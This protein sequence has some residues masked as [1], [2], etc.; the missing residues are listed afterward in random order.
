MKISRPDY[1]DKIR[2]KTENRWKQLEGDPELAAPWH[3]LFKQVQSTRHVISELLQ[4][5]DDAGATE[6][7]SRIE[8]KI[9]TFA[10]NGQ[11]F[12]EDD[13]ASLCRFGYSNKRLL[14]TIGFRGIGFKS[15]FSLGDTV[16]LLTPTLTVAFHRKNFTLPV[17]FDREATKDRN[18]Q[19]LVEIAD[20]Q[21]QKD[22]SNNMQVWLNSPFSLL[23]FNHIRR[24]KLGDNDLHWN[25]LGTGP[26]PNSEW[27]ALQGQENPYLVIRSSDEP[28]PDEALK[29]I[30]DE[31]LLDLAENT[32][33]PPC[34][35]EIVLGALGQFFVVLPTEIKTSLPFAVNAP[36]VQE[37][38]RLK[39]KD[40]GISPTNR[41]LLQR[42]GQ[43][44]A[45]AMLYWLERDD[46][47]TS[48]RAKAYDLLPTPS[49]MS[50]SLESAC[51]Q[52][53]VDAFTNAIQGKPYVLTNEGNLV[54]AKQCISVPSALWEI[55]TRDEIIA[56]LDTK[57]LNP[58]LLSNAISQSNQQKL[59]KYRAILTA[60]LDVFLHI[61]TT[62]H[63]PRPKNW[64]A[65]LE[66]WQL[67]T[68]GNYYWK[69]KELNLYPVKGENVLYSAKK[70]TRLGE[71]K[72]L[73]SEK[74]WDFLAMHLLVL[75]SDWLHYLAER[76]R[77]AEETN[78]KKLAEKI[79]VADQFLHRTNLREPSNLDS[80]I[81]QI[82]KVFFAQG[83]P[84]LTECVHF[85]Q[86]T[87]KLNAKVGNTFRFRT[88]D[89]VL[90]PA[91]DAFLFD[92]TG[93][94]E[95]FLPIKIRNQFLLHKMYFQTFTSCS[96]VDWLN[97]IHSGSARIKTYLPITKTS[98]RIHG[99]QSIEEK[100]KARGYVRAL[101]YRYTSP[102]FQIDDW[103][104]PQDFWKYWDACAQEDALLWGRLIESFLHQ[105][106][107]WDYALNAQVLHLAKN[108]SS[109]VINNS[110][111]IPAW[112]LR[113][114]ALPCLRDTRGKY[115][116]PAELFR[117][118]P[119]TEP[120]LDVEPFVDARLD[121]E[122]AR[123]LLDLLGVRSVPTGPK[124][125]IERLRALV[126][127]PKPSLLQLTKWYQ[128]L[129][130]LFDDCSTQDQ[131]EIRSLFHK[132][133]LI[134]AEDA[135]LQT[136]AS[137]YITANENDAPGAALIHSSINQLSLW[138]K[139]GVIERPTVE[140]AIQ[141]LKGL[142]SGEK[143]STADPR[144]VEALLGRHPIR[145]WQECG[146]WLNLA[147]EWVPV[148]SLQFS[149]TMQSLI[150]WTNFHDWVKA[151]TA[152]LKMLNAELIREP[153][154]VSWPSL[155]R[156]V[157]KRLEKPPKPGRSMAL[158]WLQ[159][160]GKILTRIC[161]EDD[162]QTVRI[163]TLAARLAET[164]GQQV[165][166]LRVI[167]YL[168]GKPAGL[169]EDEK[170]A[171]V[172]RVLYVTDIPKAR[173]IRLTAE[174]IAG[175]FDWPELKVT[176]AYCFE[177]SE[178]DIRAYLDENF[179]LA[180]DEA[181]LKAQVAKK[182]SALEKESSSIAKGEQPDQSA[183]PVISIR[184]SDKGEMNSQAT[185][186]EVDNNSENPDGKKGAYVSKSPQSKTPL[187]ER[188]AQACD[189]HKNGS[190]QFV[191][192]DGNNLM[193]DEGV[194]PWIIQEPGGTVL[195]YYWL[196][197]HCLQ[198]KPLEIPTDVWHLIEEH[199][200]QYA[201]ILED[202]NGNPI[203]MPGDNLLNLKECEILRLSPAT[204]RLTLEMK[205]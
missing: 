111:L 90:R 88:Q 198:T 174:T 159:G 187:I 16:G 36:F 204:Y 38:S 137:I 203:E 68:Q 168:N 66:L 142:P 104:F 200:Q 60:E 13:F 189:F 86:I 197:E 150:P 33:L 164:E 124:Q 101:E 155:A 71:K 194:F 166:I 146:H 58:C 61:I 75:D 14:R 141:W 74:D 22:L 205:D 80:I 91:T 5:A 4:N 103:D 154:F 201:L 158:A 177:R 185:S 107:A 52:V 54:V 53:I 140:L 157:E 83:E 127:A 184:E 130:I 192:N 99:K 1:F 100:V 106:S 89:G 72:I 64:F 69:S 169:P 115:R 11:D 55:W 109:R 118:T 123:P 95:E 9:F 8:N 15:T 153:P 43:L 108:G 110:H 30:R 196:K 151:E 176:L 7:S 37:P 139:I 121:N 105:S 122:Q 81:E 41:W 46:L 40:P 57:Y 188:F 19:I 2:Q 87:A 131:Q 102:D 160:L 47:E 182:K 125:I 51:R 25:S 48:E 26:I 199:P 42:I 3:Q 156:Q 92:E 138:R 21:R 119:Q 149:L 186:S 117:R 178:Q 27:M 180:P 173:R 77:I 163:R 34:K 113:L 29:E 165:E 44:A 85:T 35:V 132:E 136:A 73:Q 31:R 93:K 82:A 126:R 144:R 84:E 56:I 183:S 32:T 76:R 167:P 128:R 18:T 59:Q 181:I 12:T 179:T 17:W 62:Q 161:L 172:D 143:L 116:Q 129:D 97:W 152:N 96:K 135:T 50:D 63:P 145:I 148:E 112:I 98:I 175:V 202:A 23:F 134:F 28:F 79:D 162:N 20:E 10:H 170:L 94:L 39:I 49:Q 195:R 24:L 171:W 133:R 70:V 6:V 120:L 67:A 65:L 45:A 78:D 147:G 114:R 191:H 193:K 190:H